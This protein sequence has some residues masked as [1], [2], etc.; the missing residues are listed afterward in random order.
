MK[1]I[2]FIALF[3]VSI[4][5]SLST[6]TVFAGTGEA[7][8]SMAGFQVLITK[9]ELKKADDT[10][11]TVYTGSDY[12]ETVGTGAGT[13]AGELAATLPPAGT[14]VG[15]RVTYS[16]FKIKVKIVDGGIDYYTTAQ[17]ITEGE[18]WPLSTDVADY[19]YVTIASLSSTGF[20]ALFPTD[21]VISGTDSETFIWALQ[22]S[23]VVIYDGTMPNGVTWA[24]EGDLVVAILPGV[25]AKA[26]QFNLVITKGGSPDRSNT[27]T[28]LYDSIGNLLGG[29]SFRPSDKAINGAFLSTGSVTGVTNNGN[30]ATFDMS[31]LDGDNTGTTYQVTGSYDCGTGT[32]GP[33]SS[34][35]VTDNTPSDGWDYNFLISDG[36][37]LTTT[38][39]VTC[40]DL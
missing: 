20:E 32:N 9:L 19:D 34:L 27:I 7:G 1:Q 5:L 31:F 13:F 3:I 6:E 24:E 11:E 14:Y 25:P 21:L 15:F 39:N 16:G 23:G 29:F 30:G 2:L 38:G 40:N 37:V 36:Y 4:T 8:S 33:Y 10:Y 28:L 22:R 35:T 12:L 26:V 17:S 18:N